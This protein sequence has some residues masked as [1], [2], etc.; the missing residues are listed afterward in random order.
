MECTTFLDWFLNWKTTLFLAS[1]CFGLAVGGFGI[2]L[3]RDIT[4][5][6]Q[7]VARMAVGIDA[8]I[9]KFEK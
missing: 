5:L 9:Q 3:H 7:Q 2:S 4:I 8:V 1:G 6:R